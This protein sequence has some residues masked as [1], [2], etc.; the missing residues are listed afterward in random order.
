M[1]NK[2]TRFLRGSL[3]GIVLLCVCVFTAFSLHMSG[4][5][6][7]AI[8]QVGTLYMSRMSQQ[9]SSHFESIIILHMN[10]LRSL[11]DTIP[12]AAVHDDPELQKELIAGGKARDFSYLGF[13]GSDGSIRMLYG[14][15]VTVT[16]PEPFLE[17]L[18]NDQQKVAI[19][20]NAMEEKVVLL[21]MPSPLPRRGGS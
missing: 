14:A 20:V 15:P 8:N 3:I 17:S 6:A 12:S 7:Q 2:T 16:D 1:N 11:A 10:Q 21:G 4:Q 18:E 5:S 19:G 9:T 13:C